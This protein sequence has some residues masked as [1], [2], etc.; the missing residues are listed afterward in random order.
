MGEPAT[1]SQAPG[2]LARLRRGL[3]RLGV[4]ALCVSGLAAVMMGIALSMGVHCP[5]CDAHKLLDQP[6]LVEI[7]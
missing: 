6:R 3:T 2:R 4:I 5:E 1:V 7:S